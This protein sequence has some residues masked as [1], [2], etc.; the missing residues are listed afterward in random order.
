MA[1]SAADGGAGDAYDPMTDSE[2]MPRKPTDP[3]W[4]YAYY[5]K[6][7]NLSAVVCNLCKKVTTGGIKRQ[8]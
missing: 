1:E 7:G 5:L 4:K 8:K 6:P 3:G 2:R